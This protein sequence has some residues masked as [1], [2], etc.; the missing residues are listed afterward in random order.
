[1]GPKHSRQ[2]DANHLHNLTA[3]TGCLWAV[4]ETNRIANA[5]PTRDGRVKTGGV[6]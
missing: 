3:N 4:F 6:A 2:L 5:W 1:M